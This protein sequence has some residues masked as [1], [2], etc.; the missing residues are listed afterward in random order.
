MGE[1][2]G[3]AETRRA[4]SP[5]IEASDEAVDRVFDEDETAGAEGYPR[6]P[7]ILGFSVA[8]ISTWLLVGATPGPTLEAFRTADAPCYD[9]A[10][11]PQMSVV[12]THVHFRP[13]GGPVVPFE[14]LLQYFAETGVLFANVYG[15]GQMLPASSSCTYYLDCLGTPVTPTLKNDFVNAANVGA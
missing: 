5:V 11:Q 15:I 14:E 13:F 1:G 9:R 3:T 4:G 7:L 6:L 8:G 10:A 12:D 2:D